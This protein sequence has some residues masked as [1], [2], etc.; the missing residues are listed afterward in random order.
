MSIT[1]LSLAIA[2]IVTALGVLAWPLVFFL[3][4]FMFD[5]PGSS[6]STITVLLA[7]AFYLYPI[8]AI[9]GNIFFWGAFRRKKNLESFYYFLISASGYIVVLCLIVLLMLV[10]DG[11]F[12]CG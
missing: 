6:Q 10:C 2:S 12:A 5:A 8:P 1:R 9:I 11:K 7:N 3:S 4:V